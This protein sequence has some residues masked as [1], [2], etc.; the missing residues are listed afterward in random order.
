[1]PNWTYNRI[2]C[3]KKLADE[4]LT[5]DNDRYILDFNKL[6]PMPKTLKLVAGSI[7]KESVACYYHS[8]SKNDRKKL[9]D[10]LTTKKDWYYGNYYNKYETFIKRCYK[11]KE[12]LNKLRANYNP[13]NY[14]SEIYK[15]IDN[16]NEL[17]KQYVDNIINYDCP[18][19]YD[20]CNKNWGTKWNVLDEVNVSYN[21]EIDEYEISF[22]TA[23]S[24]PTGIFKKYFEMCKDGELNWLYEDEDYD[25]THI[26]TKENGELVDR[27]EDYEVKEEY[28]I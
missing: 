26:L 19:W 17:G 23:W 28:E 4:L 14:V 13:D 1:M 18:H 12:L 21:E 11:E 20:W 22:S 3:K 8:L 5:K 9:K 10:I 7:E 6:I 2:T 24:I 25:G 27:V 15:R 16:I